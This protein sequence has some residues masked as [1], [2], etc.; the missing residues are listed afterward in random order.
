MVESGGCVRGSMGHFLEVV[1]H[2]HVGL[3]VVHWNL[4]LGVL[5]HVT[6]YHVFDLS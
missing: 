3:L 2:S 1:C 4:E 5:L 6:R